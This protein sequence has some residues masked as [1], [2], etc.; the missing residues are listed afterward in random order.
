MYCQH[1][2]ASSSFHDK[3]TYTLVS[4]TSTMRGDTDSA[5][6][7]IECIVAHSVLRNLRIS[8]SGHMCYDTKLKQVWQVL[9]G[10]PDA[11]ADLW[12][13]ISRDTRHV[14]DEDTVSVETAEARK[15]PLGWGLRLSKFEQVDSGY[16]KQDTGSTG[17]TQ[18]AYKSFL[19]EN[20]GAERALVD[21]IVMNAVVK[22]AK[23]GITGCFLYNDRT[24]TVYQVL[25]GPCEAVESVWQL[26]RHDDRHSICLDSVR[27]RSVDA[28][29]FPNWSM[30]LSAVEQ[31]AWTAQSW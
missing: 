4:Y 28:R 18:V 3:E 8:V 5:L 6:R 24:L 10:A 21:S 11:V 17:L 25:E 15:Y 20:G 19:K 13:L 12:D 30:S 22:N 31:P 9:E 7:Q 26:I 2:S 23:L 29:E 14:I 1:R 16:Q 27:R